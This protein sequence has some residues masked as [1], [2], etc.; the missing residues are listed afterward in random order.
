MVVKNDYIFWNFRS[1][2][3]HSLYNF[4]CATTTIKGLLLSSVTN[5]KALECV[6]LLCV[7]LAFD[8]LTLN[9]CLT[10]QVTWPTLLPSLKTLQLFVHELRVITFPIVH[11]WKCV[12]GHC[13]CAGSSDPG[14]VS[15]KR[16]H[17]WNPRFWL[18]YSLYKFYLATTMIKGRLLSS[19]PMLNPFSGEKIVP[20]KWVRNM[21][22]LEENGDRNV[23]FWFRD[24]QKTLPCAEPRWLTYFASKS[25]HASRL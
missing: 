10:W 11:Q 8:R 7:T 12:R 15:Q 13:A 22:V 16:L 2:F 18:A 14:V 9:S 17:F 25:V 1:R 5:A 20:S 19:R 3:A 24:P 4:Y 21:A 6:N 23:R